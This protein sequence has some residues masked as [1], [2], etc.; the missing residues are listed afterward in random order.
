MIG[1]SLVAFWLLCGVIAA[2]HDF[3]TFQRRYPNLRKHDFE[4][5]KSGAVTALVFGPI[6]LS[7]GF[8]MHG[9]VNGWLWP[10]SKKAKREAGIV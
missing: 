1:I 2:G 10:W 4:K 5:D 8:F 7:V 6:S 3:A 9:T